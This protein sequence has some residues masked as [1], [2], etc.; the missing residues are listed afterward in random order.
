MEKQTKSN[1]LGVAAIRSNIIYWKYKKDKAQEL[2][3]E[4][5]QELARLQ[6]VYDKMLDNEKETKNFPA[7]KKAR[8]VVQSQLD[9]YKDMMSD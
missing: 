1:P 6:V 4:A 8:K 7:V 2:V 5:T 9:F 3:D